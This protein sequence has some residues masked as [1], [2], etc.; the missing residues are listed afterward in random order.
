M[1][2][3]SRQKQGPPAVLRVA[4]TGQGAEEG[5]VEGAVEGAAEGAVDGGADDMTDG[6]D[7]GGA[8]PLTLEGAGEREASAE[9]AGEAAPDGAGA[10]DGQVKLAMQIACTKFAA[11][12]GS[13]LHV[14]GV[15]G[16]C[17]NTTAAPVQLGVR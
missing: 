9:A 15:G 13:A 3:K 12:A 4:L 14:V 17:V 8:E 10:G 7:D 11:F 6:I 16:G 1:M 5:C 2:E